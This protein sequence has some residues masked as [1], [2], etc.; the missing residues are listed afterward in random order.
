MASESWARKSSVEVGTALA[1]IEAAAPTVDCA[2]AEEAL[3]AGSAPPRPLL[4][5]AELVCGVATS[6]VGEPN[7][8]EGEP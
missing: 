6:G 3:L 5:V 8:G 2:F 4:L 7:E 1:T